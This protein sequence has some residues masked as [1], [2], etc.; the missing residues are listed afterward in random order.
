MATQTLGHAGEKMDLLIRQG[1]DF[2]PVTATLTDPDGSP[3]DL[4]GCTF[5]G[6]IRRTR[7][8]AELVA[9]FAFEI[10]ADPTTG[11]VAWGL[12][13]ATTAAIEAGETT[14]DRASRYVYD[15]EMEDASGRV[16]PVLYGDVIVQ[17]ESTR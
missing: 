5:R 9:A 13:N 14:R 15:I 10:A 3:C 2:G 17:S 4:T 1:A 8:S 11:V 16:T 6:H 12:D 7:L